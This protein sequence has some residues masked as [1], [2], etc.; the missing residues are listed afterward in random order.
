MTGNFPDAE[1]LYL[2]AIVA[3]RA[4]RDMTALGDAMGMLSRHYSRIGDT[5][6]S[7]ELMQ[8][9]LEI[10]EA[11]ATGPRARPRVQPARR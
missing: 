2:A 6:R 7:Q 4:Q 9:A 3:A 5:P 1:Q 8:E 10:L 11:E